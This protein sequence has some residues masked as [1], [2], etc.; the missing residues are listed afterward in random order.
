MKRLMLS[1][2]L[3]SALAGCGGGTGIRSTLYSADGF[4]GDRVGDVVVIEDKDHGVLVYKLIQGTGKST[5]TVLV[6]ADSD[7]KMPEK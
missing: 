6:K 4:F 7:W 2:L 3:L 1:A 5:M